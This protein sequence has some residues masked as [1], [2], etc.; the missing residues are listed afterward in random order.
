MKLSLFFS[1]VIVVTFAIYSL[2]LFST[3]VLALESVSEAKCLGA[4][5]SVFTAIGCG[6]SCNIFGEVAHVANCTGTSNSAATFCCVSD[7]ANPSGGASYTEATAL[8]A[9]TAYLNDRGVDDLT[10]AQCSQKFDGTGVCTPTLQSSDRGVCKEVGSTCVDS[11]TEGKRVCCRT[12]D[13]DSGSTTTV[14]S[15]YTPLEPIPGFEGAKSF[16]D[17][18]ISIYNFAV[19]TVGIAAMFMIVIGGFMYITSAGNTSALGRAKQ[20]LWDAVFGLLVVMVT[21][22]VLYVINP[23][24]VQ[25]SR[26]L[27]I[28][29][30]GTAKLESLSSGGGGG[31]RSSSSQQYCYNSDGKERCF[32]GEK[33]CKDARTADSKATSDCVMKVTRAGG[34][35]KCEPV[36]SGPCSVENLAKTCFGSN[37]EIMSI[38]CNKESKGNPGINS[39]IDIC[40][41]N[42]GQPLNPPISFSGGLFQIE[43]FLHGG[44]LGSQCANLG[45]RGTCRCAKQNGICPA[46][47][48]WNCNA[49]SLD[50][51]NQCIALA[52]TPEAAINLSCKLSRNGANRNPWACSANRCGLGGTTINACK[53]L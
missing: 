49:N 22:L 7:L 10:D 8:A 9:F 34:N 38:V 17:Y 46:K 27:L 3:S 16:E 42:R 6:T 24:L 45:S 23:D 11:S 2:F 20:V 18:L 40:R 37:A 52:H 53:G 15:R 19:W 21:W 13:G 39:T 28:L 47:C 41:S 26:N 36:A 4:K 32:G 50:R 48:G 5:G 14:S 44:K 35:G 25:I 29:K 33:L 31:G 51:L 12:G 43:I 1:R 30:Q